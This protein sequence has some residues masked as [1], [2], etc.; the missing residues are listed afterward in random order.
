MVK[1]GVFLLI[2]LLLL[3]NSVCFAREMSTYTIEELRAGRE[4]AYEA[5]ELWNELELQYIGIVENGL[6]VGAPEWTEKDQVLFIQT[7]DI[8]NVTFQTVPISYQRYIA[9]YT[10]YVATMQP[11]GMEIKSNIIMRKKADKD[12]LVKKVQISVPFQQKPYL[13]ENSLMLPLKDSIEIQNGYE[14]LMKEKYSN[15][16]RE[17]YKEI[18]KNNFSE[19][20]NYP[21]QNNAQKA[22]FIK[23]GQ[24]ASITFDGN[25]VIFF[26]GKKEITV[27]GVKKILQVLPDIQEKDV[28]ISL[29]DLEVIF[30]KKVKQY[31]VKH[32][33]EIYYSF[34]EKKEEDRVK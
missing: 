33:Q 6:V 26:E 16:S 1:K 29:E 12:E 22:V 34:E 31:E 30:D 23:E 3:S 14:N 4:K 19:F 28:F 9:P 20:I 18:L 24:K 11:D 32:K 15:L 17:K 8:E 2:M 27:N 25:I 7:T 13:K 21:Y 10:S 5:K